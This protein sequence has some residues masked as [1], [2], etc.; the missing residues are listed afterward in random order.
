MDKCDV[1]GFDVINDFIYL[2]KY[3]YVVS[4]REIFNNTT[5]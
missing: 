2:E 1:I 5:S 4:G 3:F